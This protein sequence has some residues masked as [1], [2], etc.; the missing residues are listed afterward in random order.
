MGDAGFIRKD[1][2]NVTRGRMATE[3]LHPQSYWESQLKCIVSF[4]F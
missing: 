3:T 4:S 2:I 1:T